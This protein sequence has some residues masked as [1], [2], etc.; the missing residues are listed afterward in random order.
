MRSMTSLPS[1]SVDSPRGSISEPAC[2]CPL[3]HKPDTMKKAKRLYG[4]MVCKKCHERFI[5]KRMC[6]FGIDLLVG[7]MI[8][9]GL[10]VSSCYW[11]D[12]H[13]IPISSGNLADIRDS[14]IRGYKTSMRWFFK[15]S[16]PWTFYLVLKD[17]CWFASP[18]K[19]LFGFRV[20]DE[21]TGTPI[22]FWRSFKRNWWLFLFMP[23]SF[24]FH[25]LIDPFTHTQRSVLVGISGEMIGILGMVLMWRGPR[26]GDGWARSRVVIR[27]KIDHP[28]FGIGLTHC[29]R[30]G[31]DLRRNTT[32]RC[33]ECGQPLT[34]AQQGKL[35]ERTAAPTPSRPASIDNA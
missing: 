4:T 35:A 12:H 1:T 20:V 24:L 13:S 19:W 29:R 15:W 5:G 2:V 18:G 30:C 34:L 21:Q 6:A 27:K 11:A 17:G 33:P 28:V 31:Y 22:G 23:L 10:F 14:M 16:L 8:L 26:W 25:T 7:V 3:C 32:D 9:V